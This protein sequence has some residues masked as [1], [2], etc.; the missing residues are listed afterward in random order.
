MIAYLSSIFGYLLNFFYNIIGN[1]GIAIILFSLTIKILMIPLSIKQQ[2][3]QKKSQKLQA[4]M[5]QIQFK[6]KN[7]PE[8]M[9]Q[10]TMELYKREKMSPFSGCL[11]AILQMIILFSVFYMVREPLTYLKK[12]DS[13]LIN[14]YVT[15]LKEEQ[16]IP[17]EAYA[18]IGVI[19][20]ANKI[21]SLKEENAELSEQEAKIAEV[22]GEELDQICT[23][24][25]F[26]GIDLSK[27]PT[28]SMSD[29]RVFIIPVLYVI[30]SFVSIKL[31]TLTQ[32]KSKKKEEEE[33]IEIKG[34]DNGTE[35]AL[36]KVEE[37]DPMQQA[38]KSMSMIMP[39]MAVS[40]SLIAPL[41]LALY[42]LT[43]NLLMIAERLVLD[44]IIKSEEE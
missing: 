27:V 39:I 19:G 28:Q 31:T 12:M 13:E 29:F 30:S 42:W 20:E 24:M 17:N 35:Q 4:E 1:Y 41:G 16:L 18:Q 3:S 33:V 43:N 5:K 9:N 2:K 15:T 6:Y 25:N 21:K 10:A 40:I 11:L 34:E 23:N 44:K 14:K 36:E 37:E 7:D 26:L 38:S 8:K 22:F 32:V